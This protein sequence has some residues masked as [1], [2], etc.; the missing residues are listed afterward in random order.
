MR[1]PALK[2]CIFAA[3]IVAMIASAHL[4]PLAQT[5]TPATTPTSTGSTPQAAVPPQAAND[6]GYAAEPIVIEHAESIFNMA[7]DGTGWRQLTFVARLQSDATVKQYGV[8][9][10]TYASNSEH[11]ELFYARIRHPDGTVV[12][13][14]TTDAMD[15]PSPV[16]RQAPFYSD[17]K[18]LQ[19]PIRSLRVGDT[20]EFKYRIV[21]TKAE[22]PG[23]FWGQKVFSDAAVVLSQTAELRVPTG[24]YV[25]VWSPS[26]KPV[27]SSTAAT[28]D[29][30]A[31]HI[32]LWRYSQ[33]K[34]T[35]GKEAEAAA[36]AKKKILW[37]ADQELDLE[38]G[39]LPTIAW[40]TFKS[41]E[42]VGEWYRALEA[43]RIIPDD[44]VKAKAAELTAGK[45][46]D[47]AKARALYDYVATNIRYI[48]VAF[49]IGRY[50]PHTAA[51]ILSNQYGDC[52][53]KHT[54]L[55]A[56]LSAVGI[57]SDAVLIGAGVR[58]NEAVPSPAS[59]NHLITHLT[60]AG[61]PVWLDTTAE[62]APWA[63]LVSVTRDKQALVI[64]STS[65]VVSVI[66][67]TPVDPP[68]PNV[69][70]VEAAGSLDA[71]G[72]STSR[73]AITFRG[74]GEIAARAAFRM[75]PPDKYD[76]IVQAIAK[77]IGFAGT[78]SNPEVTRPTDMTQPFKLSFDYKREKAGDWEHLRTIPEVV[79]AR[80]PQVTEM[81]PPVRAIQ[82]GVPQ[83]ET[84]TSAMKLPEGWSAI[85]PPAIH[86]KCDYATYDMT[87]RLEN[88]TV[89]ADRKIVVLAKK[90]PVSDWRAYK[91]LVD[92]VNPGKE[93]YIQLIADK[94]TLSGTSGT[95]ASIGMGTPTANWLL[96]KSTAPNSFTYQP[97]P[98]GTRAAPGNADAD[99]LIRSA[100]PAFDRRDFDA[101]QKSLD[102]AKA[103]SPEQVGLW[104]TY[105]L[106][107]LR[108]N[109]YADAFAD[110]QK[111]LTLHPD[112]TNLYPMLDS[113]EKRLNLRKERM[114][115][116]RAWSATPT[117]EPYPT[118]QLMIMLIDD[119]NPA[120]AVQAASIDR[121]PAARRSNPT[122][123][124]VLGRALL[125]AGNPVSGSAT[126]AAVIKQTTDPMTRNNAAY[127]LAQAGVEL[128]LAETASRQA[129]DQFTDQTTH[130]TLEDNPE[131][132]RAN[133]LSL[134]SNWDTLGY[135][136]FRE[137]KLD[138][139][140][141]Y[142]S[143]AWISKPSDELGEHLGD[144]LAAQG[145]KPAALA[146]YMLA[147]A[148][149][150]GNDSSH[151][152]LKALQT[153]ADAL[154]Q[155]G[156]V[157][158]IAD[159]GEA[160]LS[161]R[162][163]PLDV[164]NAETGEVEYRLLLKAGKAI[165]TEPNAARPIPGVDESIARAD[166]SRL[167]PANSQAQIV[168][169]AHVNCHSGVCELILEP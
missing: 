132:L 17:Q 146:T 153:R 95:N 94:K 31:Q 168:R 148:T 52:K 32:Y 142:I 108:R 39:K 72:V 143:A 60:L 103:L 93:R 89:Y 160:L 78:T 135:V 104:S 24:M 76:V 151:P 157:S 57:Q 105:G 147:L 45:S 1:Q 121:I 34:P 22:A 7:A 74:D 112:Q 42:E 120:D 149:T 137:G 68:F 18:E 71:N 97:A 5:T 166:F 167:F 29:A 86:A 159:P 158:N 141:S 51:E 152:Y 90:V 122:L 13:T 124:V 44:T 109:T 9:S 40:S 55:A 50:Q 129:V 110:L 81:E 10:V 127:Q 59:F 63:M 30:P 69:V 140:R 16:T 70:T 48:G 165:Q 83:T 130:S 19:L 4:R 64:P 100:Y 114:E 6:S 67:R 79:P 33:L 139:A 65:G 116:L 8:L 3:A 28:A 61:K 99:K 162:T 43:D 145:D 11:V 91:A 138:E 26:V 164:T 38:Q 123:Q 169:T 161:L 113:L 102:E 37:T 80:F 150:A 27:E 155:A 41:W 88:G 82:L 23:Q 20:L 92:M 106:L 49:G 46:T 66:A 119:G 134:A 125:L 47:E 12:E 75:L 35:A 128:P 136:L 101:A 133:R 156:V 144:I 25:N 73:I 2:F 77:G 131:T 36:E 96:L 111:E 117:P 98:L 107:A 87:Y 56:M 85:L 154:R 163:I 84:S 54:L 62:V 126:L 58:F 21:R 53:D 15:M 14:Q 115:T 118:V